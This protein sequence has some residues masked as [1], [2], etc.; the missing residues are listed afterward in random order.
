MLKLN[1]FV[2]RGKLNQYLYFL[3]NQINPRHILAGMI[4]SG[5]QD[6]YLKNKKYYL[7]LLWQDHTSGLMGQYL[8][9]EYQSYCVIIITSFQ[10]IPG[11]KGFFDQSTVPGL[12]QAVPYPKPEPI[13]CSGH[14]EYAGQAIGIIVAESAGLARA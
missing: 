3:N 2:D 14:V 12:N 7:G 9:G 4:I 13:F 6:K 1:F 11:V 8:L 5:L 10:A